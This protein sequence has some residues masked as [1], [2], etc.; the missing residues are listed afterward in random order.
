MLMSY[1]GTPIPDELD[2]VALTDR[3]WRVCGNRFP[4]SGS[5]DTLAYIEQDAAGFEVMLLRGGHA[6]TRRAD[7]LAAALALV[8]TDVR[9]GLS[10]E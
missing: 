5:P 4:G 1:E 2:F 3:T 10:A 7:C 8:A 9:D 6:E